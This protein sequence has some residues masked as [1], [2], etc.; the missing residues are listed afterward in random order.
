M[1]LPDDDKQKRAERLQ[2]ML[3]QDEIEFVDNWRFEHKMPS[4]SAAVR[5]LLRLAFEVDGR[6][7]GT[8]ERGAVG[9]SSAD[10]GIL[11]TDARVDR[12]MSVDDHD[13][14]RIV[15]GCTDLLAGH[16]ARSLLF[17]AGFDTAGPMTDAA[18]I[19]GASRGAIATILVAGEEIGGLDEIARALMA[20]NLPLLVAST[21]AAADTLPIDI[22]D[23]PTISLQS[24]PG[25]LAAAL[26]DLLAPEA[27]EPPA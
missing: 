1:R 27:I 22:G 16:A 10:V 23:A 7:P 5:A 4:R 26:K 3:T 19:R 17:E 9:V 8:D 18:D 21:R 2:L 14:E 12:L 13:A 15:I 25:A 6:S 24:M 20:L 11:S